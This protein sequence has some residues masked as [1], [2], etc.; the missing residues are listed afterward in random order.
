M[1][2]QPLENRLLPA[3][4]MEQLRAHGW[5]ISST[6]GPYCTAWKDCQEV[7]LIWK[8]GVWRRVEGP[9]DGPLSMQ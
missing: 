2:P 7:L 9:H 4:N 3:P 5:H 6:I 8:D 1:I